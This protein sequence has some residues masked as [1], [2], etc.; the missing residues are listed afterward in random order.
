[1]LYFSAAIGVAV[2]QASLPEFKEYQR[3]V[4]KNA[5]HLCEALEKHGYTIAAGKLSYA[6]FFYKD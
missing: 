3:Q 2:K 4:V 1:M 5:K 6:V